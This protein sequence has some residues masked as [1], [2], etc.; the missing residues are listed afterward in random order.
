MGVRI[1]RRALVVFGALLSLAGC[2]RGTEVRFLDSLP[3]DLYN[4]EQ[5]TS[6]PRAVHASVYLVRTEPQR[7]P[8]KPA[9]FLRPVRLGAVERNVVTPLSEIE[10]VARLLLLPSSAQERSAGFTSAIPP[11]TE[12]IGISVERGVADVNL[13]AE[14]E[15]P[16]SQLGHLMALAQVVWTLTELPEVDAVRFRIHGVAQPVID[17]NGVTHELVGQARYSRFAPRE[18]GDEGSLDGS[19]APVA[20]SGP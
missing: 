5:E 9:R 19:V 8:S 12:L 18:A 20:T 17:Q 1:V 2:S 16:T 4:P 14:F 7:D 15:T 11:D 13:S 6:E 10:A 3:R